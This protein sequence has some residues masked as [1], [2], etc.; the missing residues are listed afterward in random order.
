[1]SATLTKV[2]NDGRSVP[3]LAFGTGESYLSFSLRPLLISTATAHYNRECS[4]AILLALKKGFRFVD[5][6]NGYENEASVGKA[7]KAWDG[8]RDDL[9]I[10]SKWGWTNPPL[11]QHDP[12]AELKHSLRQMGLTCLDLCKS[13]NQLRDPEDGLG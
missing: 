13:I 5:T 4:E 7:L 10:C 9:Y 6:A 11:V 3:V 2:F 1:M 8:K 12:E